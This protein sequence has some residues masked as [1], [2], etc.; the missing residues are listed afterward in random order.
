M[1]ELI[2]T[3]SS[4]FSKMSLASPLLLSVR[5]CIFWISHQRPRSIIYDFLLLLYV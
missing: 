4:H 3:S 2:Q 5:A 1:R